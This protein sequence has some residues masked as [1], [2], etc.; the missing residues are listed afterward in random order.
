[1]T[2]QE[3]RK[4]IKE[5]VDRANDRMPLYKR[6]R[7]FEIRKTEFE[8]TASKR[9]S[10]MW[11][12]IAP[13]AENILFSRKEKK[14][15]S[16]RIRS[17]KSEGMGI[18]CIQS[19]GYQKQQDPLIRYRNNRPIIDLKHMFE[20]SV[21]LFGDRSAFH[22]KDE[23]GGVYRQITY[24]EAKA[25]VDALGTAL[26]NLGLK[27]KPIAII[28]ENSYRWAISYLAVTCGTGIVVPLDKELSAEELEQL[29][30]K[31]EVE[32]VIFDKV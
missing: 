13:I 1:M 5:E 29:V 21:E 30:D 22:T 23:H 7:R 31:G 4:L 24:K 26:I 16:Q 12:G 32:C 14:Y 15:G 6:V 18:R 10:A 28:G 9:L 11:N 19:G 8:K 27:G 25:D 20:T 17:F 2:D 3:I